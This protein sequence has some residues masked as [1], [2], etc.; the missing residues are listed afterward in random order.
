MKKILFVFSIVLVMGLTLVGCGGSSQPAASDKGSE[1]KEEKGSDS[2]KP[3][4]EKGSD[5]KP[6]AKPA[7]GSDTKPSE[8]RGSDSK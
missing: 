3:E 4:K 7:G 1:T 8:P 6:A 2:K 5:A